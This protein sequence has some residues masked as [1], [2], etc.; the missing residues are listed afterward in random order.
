MELS[1]LLDKLAE[2]YPDEPMLEEALELAGDE[3]NFDE[4]MNAG[5]EVD[6]GDEMEPAPDEDYDD[7]GEEVPELDALLGEDLADAEMD[8]DEE[9]ADGMEPGEAV[10]PTA[11]ASKKKKKPGMLA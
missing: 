6:I 9:E 11:M 3:F 8:P 2:K 4:E 1:K 5:R 10:E 7:E